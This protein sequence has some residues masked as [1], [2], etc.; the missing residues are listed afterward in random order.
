MANK[1]LICMHE[2]NFE[3][4]VQQKMEE[5]SL[6]PSAPVWQKVEEQIRKKKDRRRL[7]F[8]L[9]PLLL[10]GGSAWWLLSG[11]SD[12]VSPA[13][14]VNM[15]KQQPAPD[16]AAPASETAGA[17]PVQKEERKGST[18]EE[19]TTL[20][21]TPQNNYLSPQAEQPKLTASSIITRRLAIAREKERPAI[22][23]E[24]AASADLEAIAAT[25]RESGVNKTEA[26]AIVQETAISEEKEQV[27]VPADS[28]SAH[29]TGAPAVSA[30]PTTPQKPINAGAMPA[31]VDSASLVQATAPQQ[32]NIKNWQWTVHADA[33]VTSVL[34]RLFEL[35]TTRTYDAFNRPGQLTSGNF[36]AYYPSPQE[37]GPAFSAGITAKRRMS[38]RLKLTAGLQ[39]NYYST[40]MA[41]GQEKNAMAASTVPYARQA[42]AAAA[43][44]A[45]SYLPGIQNDYTNR[46]H[47]LQLPIG[48]EYQVL[49]NIPLQVHGGLAVAH[50]IKTNALTYD[51]RTQS[52]Y[53]NSSAYK[54]TQ[55]HLFSNITYTLWKGK[56]KKLDAG[57]FV[58]Y[59]LTELQKTA[60][61][62]NRLFSTGLRTQ[63][64]F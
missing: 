60:T 3:K 56:T 46:Y 11:T 18:P 10:A 50:L 59:S 4:Q 62:K 15:A 22:S 52:Y 54:S 41:V 42:A 43:A 2:R 1:K 55:W 39:Y 28:A 32:L 12:R 38:N 19:N 49:K 26:M 57:P 40:Q 33:G 8:W 37:E 13:A 31:A 25:E 53:Q 64:S 48:I 9:L 58:Q 36:F 21:N 47:F 35:P 27:P 24:P 51:Y 17:P 34:S 29:E 20:S 61:D 63:L 14:A 30:E 7:I 45:N 16:A 5:L 23:T 44:P 6:T